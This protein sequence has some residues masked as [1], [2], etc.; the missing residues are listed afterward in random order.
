MKFTFPIGTQTQYDDIES[1]MEAYFQRAA[2]TLLGH[3]ATRPAFFINNDVEEAREIDE[4]VSSKL[5]LPALILDSFDDELNAED[6]NV[7]TNIEVSITVIDQYRQGDALHLRQVRSRCRTILRK[8]AFQMLRDSYQHRGG[9]LILN[10]IYLQKES[11][12]GLHLGTIGGQFTG[13]TMSFRWKV[14]ES[15]NYGIEE[16][17]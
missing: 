9:A 1:F 17:A 10:K 5:K 16:W 7:Y 12:D 14:T 13:W 6:S 4:A 2:E 8:I 3:S 15:M 11:L